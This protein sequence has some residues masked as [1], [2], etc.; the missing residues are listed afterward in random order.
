MP[1]VDAL[2]AIPSP[3]DTKAQITPCD[4]HEPAAY[5]DRYILDKQQPASSTH[6]SRRVY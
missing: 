3:E 6:D 1:D 4:K 2:V 5:S